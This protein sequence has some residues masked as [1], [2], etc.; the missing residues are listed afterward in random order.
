MIRAVVDTS[1]VVRAVLKPLGTVGPVLDFLAEVRQRC[2]D[3]FMLKILVVHLDLLHG[4]PRAKQLK[5]H[6]HRVAK[7]AEGRSAVADL[8]VDGDAFKKF[9]SLASPQS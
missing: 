8:R 5:Y 1:I 3:V 2:E 7:T 4:H 9:H 6:L